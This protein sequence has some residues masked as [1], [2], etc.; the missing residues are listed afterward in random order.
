[1]TKKIISILVFFLFIVTAFGQTNPY[2]VVTKNEKEVIE[3]TKPFKS[4]FSKKF[5]Y[6]NPVDWE[7]GMRFMTDPSGY[8]T[9]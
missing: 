7:P 1:M 6:I 3:E 8:Q 9:D 5:T 2:N 4:E